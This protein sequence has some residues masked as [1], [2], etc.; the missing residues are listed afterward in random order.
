MDS[1]SL[2]C[3]EGHISNLKSNFG[4]EV[5]NVIGYLL[6]DHFLTSLAQNTVM[7]LEK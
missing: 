1:K 6:C 3:F 7:S 5:N 4:D 2:T